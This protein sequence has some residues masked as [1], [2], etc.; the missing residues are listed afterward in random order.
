MGFYQAKEDILIFGKQIQTTN[1]DMRA[2]DDIKN[3]WDSL[4]KNNFLEG[5][6]V[7]EQ[8]TLVAVY[9]DYEDKER[10]KYNYILGAPVIDEGQGCPSHMVEVTL[11]TGRYYA[12]SV[13]SQEPKDIL[14]AWKHI[15]TLDN[16]LF[17]RAFNIDYEWYQDSKMTIYLSIL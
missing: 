5:L 6:Q 10:G 3:I 1:E 12:Y 8:D 17:K 11:P 4:S 9:K 15:W 2:L 14:E 7:K 16:D 13:P